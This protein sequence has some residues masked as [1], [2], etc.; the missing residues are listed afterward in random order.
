MDEKKNLIRVLLVDDHEVVRQGLIFFLD[1]QSDVE[2]CGQASSGREA[3]ELSRTLNPDVILMDLVLPD[4]DGIQV[5]Q[6]ILKRNQAIKIIALTSY[7]D[8]AKVTQALQAGMVGYVM[9]DTSSTELIRA[10]RSAVA[11]EMHLAPQAAYQLSKSISSAEKTASEELVM[12]LTERELQVMRHLARGLS[13][14][15]IADDLAISVQTV[16]THVSNILEKLSLENRTQIAIFA[17]ENKLV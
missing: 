13:N 1:S 16:K 14:Y 15:D 2:V 7:I 10:I 17:L 12:K 4:I 11:D 3:L 6:Q 8:E 9:K 5:S